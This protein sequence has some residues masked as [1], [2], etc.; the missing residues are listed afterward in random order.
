[1]ANQICVCKTV[2]LIFSCGHEFTRT[3]SC[4]TLQHFQSPVEYRREKV[5]LRSYEEC[6]EC[7]LAVTVPDPLKEEVA[8]DELGR[9]GR[10]D[11]SGFYEDEDGR[12]GY[13]FEYDHDT[14]CQELENAPSTYC[15][16]FEKS[17]ESEFDQEDEHDVSGVTRSSNKLVSDWLR[18][19]LTDAPNLTPLCHT[20][21]ILLFPVG[22]IQDLDDPYDTSASS[23]GRTSN[24]TLRQYIPG[25]DR[26]LTHVD[27][28]F[29]KQA[30]T[31]RHECINPIALPSSSPIPRSNQTR[32]YTW[33]ISH[34]SHT[35]KQ[36]LPTYTISAP[37]L[38]KTSLTARVRVSIQNSYKAAFE[39]LCT[40]K[41]IDGRRIRRRSLNLAADSSIA[42]KLS[43]RGSRAERK[44]DTLRSMMLRR[45]YGTP[46]FFQVVVP[47]TLES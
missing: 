42:R 2:F 47:S 19:E 18:E 14:H 4:D 22:P 24:G 35:R 13:N 40:K 1:M 38:R 37:P 15:D 34:F 25:V 29:Q 3:N 46:G 11:T 36:V 33:P 41:G 32:P 6:L 8:V 17:L 26:L 16:T 31:T 5:V 20:E 30:S 39:K 21:R 23:C 10:Y 7:V 12:L 44:A 43:R 28:P 9:N 27:Q 45:T